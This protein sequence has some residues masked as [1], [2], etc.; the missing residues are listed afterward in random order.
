MLCNIINIVVF[1][2]R[3]H[4]PHGC[5]SKN[6]LSKSR[7]VGASEI[8]PCGNI[9]KHAKRTRPAIQEAFLLRG[10]GA[11]LGE[12]SQVQTGGKGEKGEQTSMLWHQALHKV[13]YNPFWNTI[14]SIYDNPANDMEWKQFLLCTFQGCQEKERYNTG[15]NMVTSNK[16][17][18][19][20]LDFHQES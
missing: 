15:R 12:T 7:S 18:A 3:V 16:K 6:I 17:Q 9:I 10:V 2:T 1:P 11:K 4:S 8:H 5:F 13:N 19:K 20:G 14:K